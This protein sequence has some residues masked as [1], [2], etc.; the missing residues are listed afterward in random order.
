[1]AAQT[2]QSAPPP[3][4]QRSTPRPERWTSF[5]DDTFKV[6]V[7]LALRSFYQLSAPCATI[8]RRLTTRVRRS[9]TQYLAG[10]PWNSAG[11]EAGSQLAV[12]GSGWC[13][14]SSSNSAASLARTLVTKKRMKLTALKGLKM[15][16]PRSVNTGAKLSEKAPTAVRRKTLDVVVICLSFGCSFELGYCSA[17]LRQTA[18][19]FLPN[20]GHFLLFWNGRQNQK[21]WFLR[22]GV[23]RFEP[24]HGV[25]NERGCVRELELFL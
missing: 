10:I 21:P 23:L 8:W 14:C 22:P 19:L 9:P 11:S 25:A 24:A 18:R 5:D 20:F 12:P 15:P 16:Q 4:S 7:P 13:R 6:P 1:M 17:R 3:C 2:G